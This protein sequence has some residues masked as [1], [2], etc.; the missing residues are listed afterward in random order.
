MILGGRM[1][2]LPYIRVYGDI[3]IEDFGVTLSSQR[4][5]GKAECQLL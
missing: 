3:P 4:E 5:F 2:S 1:A